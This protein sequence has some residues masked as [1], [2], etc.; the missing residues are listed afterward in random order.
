MLHNQIRNYERSIEQSWTSFQDEL[1]DDFSLSTVVGVAKQRGYDIPTTD[2]NEFFINLGLP[3]SKVT[4]Y[5][6]M[7]DNGIQE[8]ATTELDY[9]VGGVTAVPV[10]AAVIAVATYAAVGVSVAIVGA[11]AIFVAASIVTTVTVFTSVSS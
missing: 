7:N 10:A 3:K 11:I 1:E 2:W 9:V 4:L 6:P 8:L 5:G